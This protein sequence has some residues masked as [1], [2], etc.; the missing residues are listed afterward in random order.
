MAICALLFSKTVKT[1]DRYPL[2]NDDITVGVECSP[3]T[4]KVN[5]MVSLR[6]FFRAELPQ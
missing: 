1:N 5:G 6:L 4:A 2:S 3:I